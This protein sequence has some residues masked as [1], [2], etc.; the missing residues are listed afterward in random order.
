MKIECPLPAQLCSIEGVI[1]WFSSWLFPLI[2]L[3][4]F[5][6]LIYGGI[7]KMTAAGDA[8][9]EKLAMKIIQ[10]AI[11]GT[12]IIILARVIMEG[13]GALLNVKLF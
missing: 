10:N 13:L 3:A 7:T 12:A 11:I 9:K 5:V 2:G 8:E 1:S 6:M 4:L